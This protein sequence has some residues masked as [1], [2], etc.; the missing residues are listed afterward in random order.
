MV[1]FLGMKRQEEL[2][3]VLIVACFFALSILVLLF[4]LKWDDI[5]DYCRR[6]CCWCLQRNAADSVYSYSNLN[7]LLFD[8]DEHKEGT[9][10]VLRTSDDGDFIVVEKESIKLDTFFSNVL[11]ANSKHRQESCR[12]PA[13]EPLL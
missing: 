1:H 11:S 3:A 5:V 7:E 6:K 10:K 13:E 8:T 2:K 12:I 4:I 9:L